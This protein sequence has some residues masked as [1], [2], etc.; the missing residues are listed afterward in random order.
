MFLVDYWWRLIFY[1]VVVAAAISLIN[2]LLR[3]LLKVK[4]KPLFSSNYLNDFHKKGDRIIRACTVIA[5]IF[6]YLFTFESL[7]RF[8]LLLAVASSVLTEGFRA[9]MEK[10]YA[11]NPKD[12]LYTLCQ[13][14]VSL[15]IPF[16]FAWLLFPSLIRELLNII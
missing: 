8:L 12:Y 3:K 11:E 13:L 10:K 14:P 1:L 5:V 9:I 7:F 15:I 16:G 2:F 6:V 4:R